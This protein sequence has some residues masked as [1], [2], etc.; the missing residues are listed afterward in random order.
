M[1]FSS[2]TRYAFPIFPLFIASSSSSFLP[3]LPYALHHKLFVHFHSANPINIHDAVA[4]FNRMLH[5]RPPPSVHKIYKILGSLVKMK[6]YRTVISLFAQAEFKRFAPCLVSL[7]ILTNCYCHVGRMAFAFSALGK[8]FKRGHHPDAITLT[9]LM[10]GLCIK[11]QVGKALDI[12][13]HLVAK[14]FQ[15]DRYTYGTLING[16]VNQDKQDLPLNFS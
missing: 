5:M 10:K 6:H 11:N 16:Y 15:F 9:T 8:L 4:S 14:G 2:V 12:H 1:S 7:S 13:Y 3:S